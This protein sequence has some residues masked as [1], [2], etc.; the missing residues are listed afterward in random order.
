MMMSNTKGFILPALLLELFLLGVVCSSSISLLRHMSKAFV[1][2]KSHQMIDN[3]ISKAL[4]LLY[5][6]KHRSGSIWGLPMYQWREADSNHP[7]YINESLKR[8]PEQNMPKQGSVLLE[9]VDHV[10]LFFIKNET[11]GMSFSGHVRSRFIS[12]LNQNRWLLIHLDGISKFQAQAVRTYVPSEEK[13]TLAFG[14]SDNFVKIIHE[15]DKL[16]SVALKL[17]QAIM[18][19][20]LIDHILV[21]VNKRNELRRYSLITYDNQPLADEIIQISK[22]NETCVITAGSKVMEIR[23]EFPCINAPFEPFLYMDFFGV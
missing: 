15:S 17:D 12:S 9:V 3:S 19:T 1:Y 22:D 5:S 11:Q 6:L 21:Y 7:S 10:P 14:E 16:H 20:P 18:V 23:Q 4:G 13:W 8:L 2:H